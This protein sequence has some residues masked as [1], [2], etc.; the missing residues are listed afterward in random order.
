MKA[1]LT[2]VRGGPKEPA[3]MLTFADQ[4]TVRQME[5][6]R[7]AFDTWWNVQGGVFIVNGVDLSVVDINLDVSG[8]GVTLLKSP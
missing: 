8:N 5:G 1:T 7:E 4:L 3:A 2:I 6:L